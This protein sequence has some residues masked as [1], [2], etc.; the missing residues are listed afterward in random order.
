MEEKKD[1]T[2]PKL[3]ISYSWTNPQH[4][5]WVLELATSLV[6]SGVDVILDKWN[7][8]EGHDAVAFMEKMVTDPDINKVLLVTDEVYASKADGRAGGVGTETQIISKK[9]YENQEQDKFVAVISEKDDSGNPFLPTYYESRVFIDLSEP[10]RYSENFEK[11]LR[12]VFN[13]PLYVK[14]ELGSKP[15]FLQTKDS[16]KLGTNTSHRRTMSAIREGKTFAHGSLDEYLKMYAANLERFRLTEVKGDIDEAIVNNIEEF[17]PYRN[18]LIELVF[19]IAQYA[20]S[21]ENIL[22]LHRFFEEILP[23]MEPPKHITQWNKM[24]FD[25]FKFIVH[26]LFLYTIAILIKYEKFDL[27]NIFLSQRYYLANRDSHGSEPMVKFTIF[28]EYLR[29][30]DHRNK[31]LGLNRLSLRADLLEQGSKSSGLDF[32]FLM[33]A[34]FVLFM[35]AEIEDEHGYADWWPE[36]LLYLFR[37]HAA[38]EIFARSASASY[39]EK[40][41]VMLNISTKDDLTK[42]LLSYKSGERQL[43]RWSSN[44]IN[45]YGLLGHEQLAT[46]P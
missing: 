13:K 18:E 36:T 11:L 34:D 42:L 26:E 45:P 41:K 9:V 8:K 27:A 20:P 31:R 22:R 30:L 17:L 23:Y 24:D 14:P 38:F 21:V 16:V 6:E 4:E 39:F 33:Q 43:P 44:S 2:A 5:E 7:L 28:R 40:V 25:N 37:F 12:W 19:V 15:A 35:R 32:R 3:F 29:S 1:I 46:I 10:D